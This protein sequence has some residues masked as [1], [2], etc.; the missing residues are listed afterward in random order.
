MTKEIFELDE[1][2]YPTEETLDYVVNYRVENVNS[3]LYLFEKV[4]ELWWNLDYSHSTEVKDGEIVHYISTLGWSGNESL[5]SALRGNH[6]FWILYWAE[7]R[8]GG[9]YKF[10]FR[11]KDD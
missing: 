6:L 2:G 7:S 3:A 8:R 1:D 4:L 9:H 10:A 5:I 11:I